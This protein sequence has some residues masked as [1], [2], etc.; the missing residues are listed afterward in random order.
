MTGVDLGRR[1]RCPSCGELSAECHRC[2]SCGHDFASD[3]TTAAREE[4]GRSETNANS[5]SDGDSE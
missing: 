3:S 4:L 5:G 1:W 2:D